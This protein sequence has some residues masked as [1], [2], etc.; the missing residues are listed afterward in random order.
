MTDPDDLIKDTLTWKLNK[1]L[2]A[3]EKP[4]AYFLF[5]VMAHAIWISL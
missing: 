3:I 2:T 4:L 1:A 5:G